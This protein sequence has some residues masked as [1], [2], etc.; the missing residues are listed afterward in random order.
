MSDSLEARFAAAM[1]TLLGP[2]F[3][4]EIALAVSG[5]GDSMAMLT[6]AHN[7]TRAWGLHL[8]VVTVDH[9]FRPGAADEAAMV[10]EECA[11]LGHD[12][13]TLH[14]RWDGQGNKMDAA[15][16]GRLE[17]IDAW[18]GELRHVLMAHTR[19]D[20]AETFLMR[21]AR[22][23]GVE[24]L[25]AMAPL[26]HLPARQPGAEGMIVVRPCLDMGREELRH[27][28]RT[29]KGQWVEDPSNEDPRYDRVRARRLLSTLKEAGIDTATLSATA[30]RMA[31]AREALRR[32]ALD[33]WQSI[34]RSD[35]LTGEILF[36]RDALAGI[37]R[38]TQ[39]RLLAA[40][41]QAVGSAEYRPR[42]APLEALLDRLLA[43]GAGT[44]HGCEA[45]AGRA[46]LRIYREY[47]AVADEVVAA[48]PGAVWDRRWRLAGKIPDGLEIR[49]LGEAGWAQSAERPASAPPHAVARAAPAL[50]KGDL[51]YACPAM[52]HGP[53][54]DLRLTPLGQEDAG[55]AAALLS[56]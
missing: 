49:A 27:Y 13:T 12:H 6:L 5:G 7:W 11:L 22:G 54:V 9:G 51:L 17:A 2:G 45:R 26:R 35:P 44:L 23:S 56:H 47:A 36:D 19:D 10:A 4:D 48:A 46:W 25:S 37:E 30:Q 28:L 8:R 18:R 40:A 50:W 43:G 24:G 52:C 29:L 32:R 41:L 39:L 34:G 3:P 14:W 20:V 42:A 21:L 31:R 15:R 33:V 38:D 55:L 16:R 1:G 53:A